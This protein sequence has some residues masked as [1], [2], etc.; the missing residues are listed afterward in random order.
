MIELGELA[1]AGFLRMGH[2]TEDVSGEVRNSGRGIGNILSLLE[3]NIVAIFHERL[4]GFLLFEAFWILEN[5]SEVGHA[6]DNVS[7]REGLLQ[8][9]HIVQISL[10]HLNPFGLPCLCT[11]GGNV[12]RLPTGTR[13]VRV[14]NRASL[15][16]PCQSSWK[17][18]PESMRHIQRSTAETHLHTGNAENN[19][20]ARHRGGSKYESDYEG[21]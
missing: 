3:L 21:I 16:L 20:K 15:Q 4:A 7:P 13:E 19:D 12:A 5:C 9:L 14:G 10:D 11:F 6:E 18:S 8:G 2:R 17:L 1:V